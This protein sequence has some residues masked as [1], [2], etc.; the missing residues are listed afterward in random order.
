MTDTTI[1]P[2]RIQIPEAQLDDLRARLERTRWPDEIADDADRG[3]PL[4]Y[5]KKLAEYWRSG[6]DWRTAEARINAYPQSMLF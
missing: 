6:Y 1:R 3:V 5:V 2:F 4:A